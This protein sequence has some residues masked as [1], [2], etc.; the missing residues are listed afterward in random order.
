MGHAVN[1]DRFR[2]LV[3]GQDVPICSS[4]AV[5]TGVFEVPGK[6]EMQVGHTG[7]LTELLHNYCEHTPFE[8]LVNDVKVMQ[9]EIDTL[10]S[11]GGAGTEL[12][13]TGRDRL[14]R[15]F[16]TELHSD[17][18][19]SE[20]SFG[21]LLEIALA[22]VGLGDVSVVSSNLANRKAIT[23]KYKVTEVVNPSEE[24]TDTEI[25]ETIQTRTKTVTKSLVME[26]GT[27]WWEF[28]VTQFQRAGLFL[29]ADVFG[30]FV[31]GQPNGKQPPLYRLVRRRSGKGEQGDVNF[32][33]QPE[34]QRTVV[35]RFSEFHVTGRKGSGEDGR[36]K[37][38]SRQIDEE[39]VALLNPNEGDRANGGKR[40]RIKIHRDDK[41][42]TPAQ[43]TFLALRKLAESRRNGFSL[44]Y[45]I[46][47]HTLQALTGGGRLVLQPETVIHV[48]DEELGI[49]APMYIDGCRYPRGPQCTTRLHLTRCED[50]LFGEEDL[51]AVPP[52][53]KKGLVRMGR[54]E[55][56][57]PKWVKDPNWGDLPTL[58]SVR[59]ADDPSVRN[60]NQAPETAAG[61]VVDQGAE[62][63]R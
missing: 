38:F 42:K 8:L 22:D 1:E 35:P 54:T 29:W 41:I 36:G 20:A 61:F 16:D 53:A 19:F 56:F 57:R 33:G 40:K 14:A 10:A 30:G 48:V 13:I 62:R 23:G 11:A 50:L 37:A 12:R 21:D 25:A 2:L 60:N 4:Y 59:L 43:A 6:F 31:L 24:S 46:A 5:D 34:F 27:S 44:A 63:R 45:T 39:M 51:F 17:R 9:G 58:R 49:D 32:I 47:G 52:A 15:L 55:V 26:A 7:L 18:T 28:L 3:D